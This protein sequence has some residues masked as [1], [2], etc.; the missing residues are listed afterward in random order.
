[1]AGLMSSEKDSW[2]FIPKVNKRDFFIFGILVL[3]ILASFRDVSAADTTDPVIRFYLDNLAYVFDQNYIFNSDTGFSCIVGSI[4]E[5]TDYRGRTDK[6]DTAVYQLFYDNKIMD[7]SLLLD[8]A[9]SKENA[10]PDNFRPPQVWKENLL[11]DFYPN[12]TGAGPL[13]ISFESNSMDSS[14]AVVGFI[15]LDRNDF[16]VEALF[17]HY[18][19]PENSERISEVYIFQRSGRLIFL[20]QYERQTAKLRFFGRQFT[21]QTVNFSQYRFK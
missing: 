18:P 20:R 14:N 8:S 15:N 13:A 12:D 4:L 6:I 17:L 16:Y 1:M 5:T 11:F 19:N 9:K 10:L 2:R 21:K 3:C 7:S